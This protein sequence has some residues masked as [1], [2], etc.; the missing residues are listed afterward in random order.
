MLAKSLLFALLVTLVVAKIPP[1][2]KVCGRRNP[3]LDGCVRRSVESLRGKLREGIPELNV[4][5]LEPLELKGFPLAES[6][7]L[8]AYAEHVKVWGLTNFEL[9]EFHDDL[10]KNQ[11]LIKAVFK[12]LEL[13]ADYDIEAKILVPFKGK[14]PIHIV[15]H[16]SVADVV[17]SYKFATKNG[18]RY[19]YFSAMTI[20][21]SINDFEAHFKSADGIE[22]AI[23][24]AINSALKEGRQEILEIARPTLEKVISETIL[25]L[26]NKI[27]KSFTYDELHPDTTE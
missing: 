19:V 18:V 5:T 15:S 27:C 3:D 10:V 24:T 25:E 7:S 13:D 12:K 20:K 9:K 1:Y 23:S 26:G 4:P 17:M 16:D 14:G 21:L 8:R 2:I 22:S 11:L 6:D